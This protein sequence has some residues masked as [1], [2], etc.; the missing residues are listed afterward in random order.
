M[1]AGPISIIM[2]TNGCGIASESWH[3]ELRG[4]MIGGALWSV[5]AGRR[6]AGFACLAS[7]CCAWGAGLCWA[8][9]ND[10]LTGICSSIIMAEGLRHGRG[11]CFIVKRVRLLGGPSAGAMLSLH[12]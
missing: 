7:I 2:G 8:V 3:S 12:L 5:W 10:A 11:G 9:V 4:L 1:A 6:V